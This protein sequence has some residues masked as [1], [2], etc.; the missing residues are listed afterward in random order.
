CLLCHLSYSH[1][2]GLGGKH[3]APHFIHCTPCWHG[4]G[5][6]VELC[7]LVEPS[8]Q[9]M[10]HLHRGVQHVIPLLPRCH[11]LP[12]QGNMRVARRNLHGRPAH[13]RDLSIA[14][15]S[16]VVASSVVAL[17]DLRIGRRDPNAN[18]AGGLRPE[19]LRSSHRRTALL[20]SHS[21]HATHCLWLS[22]W[23]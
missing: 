15:G 21:L 2:S 17:T 8:A 10:L 20:H 1:S 11:S 12:L 4:L 6:P 5:H 19:R 13:E 23:P 3:A 14:D 7:E 22:T 9:V 18:L 16:A